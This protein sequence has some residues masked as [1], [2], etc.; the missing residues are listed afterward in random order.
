[1]R[2]RE[3]SGGGEKNGVCLDGFRRGD[4]G[5]EKYDLRAAD[6]MRKSG[7][8]AGSE[9]EPS[10]SDL[11]AERERLNRPSWLRSVL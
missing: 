10:H 11:I 2:K 5:A 7:T 6:E 1:M 3:A 9:A 8:Y 4:R